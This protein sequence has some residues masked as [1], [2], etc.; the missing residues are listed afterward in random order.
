[1]INFLGDTMTVIALFGTALLLLGYGIRATFRHAWRAL[2]LVVGLALA[3]L[4]GSAGWFFVV[5]AS[6]VGGGCA[7]GQKTFI[8]TGLY[9]AFSTAIAATLVIRAGRSIASSS[10]GKP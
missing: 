7:D 1:M 6:C 2:R 3:W 9:F 5:V 8:V 4:I 10:T